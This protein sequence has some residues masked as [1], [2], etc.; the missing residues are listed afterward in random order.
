MGP[1]GAP[2]TAIA[3]ALVDDD[4]GSRWQKPHDELAEA[5]IMWISRI[6]R[7]SRITVQTKQIESPGPMFDWSYLYN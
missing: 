6:S 1:G 5:T 2:N 3:H 4:A 7:V